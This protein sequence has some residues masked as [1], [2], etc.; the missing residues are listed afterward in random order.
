M[1]EASI[2]SAA[3]AGCKLVIH[4]LGISECCFV[5][6]H[7][8][9][10]SLPL[11]ANME[12]LRVIYIMLIGKIFLLRHFGACSQ[13]KIPKDTS[14]HSIQ[15]CR[16]GSFS[17]NVFGLKLRQS[18][19]N[20]DTCLFLVSPSFDH[21]KSLWQ[22]C[23]GGGWRRGSGGGGEGNKA[24]R[25]FIICTNDSNMETYVCLLPW[26]SHEMFHVSV[27]ELL[28]N[29]FQSN[30]TN[31][32]GDRIYSTCLAQSPVSPA[33]GLMFEWVSLESKRTCVHI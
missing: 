14:N 29:A 23:G 8:H 22:S 20:A 31:Y 30:H 12:E 9:S 17:S 4:G 33:Q 19:Q 24:S 21:R 2:E 7:S 13:V 25:C 16:H 18:S 26:F 5:F 27:G 28:P 6:D 11:M 15:T 3:L 1:R 32:H 10:T